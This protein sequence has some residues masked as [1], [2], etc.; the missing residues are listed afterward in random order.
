MQSELFLCRVRH[1]VD[2]RV[3]GLL[4]GYIQMNDY[5]SN[6]CILVNILSRLLIVQMYTQLFTFVLGI[7]KY[8]YQYEVISRKTSAFKL[9][10]LIFL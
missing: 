5:C 7:N 4:P 8:T 2:Y 10:N 6:I 3:T 9:D 1:L